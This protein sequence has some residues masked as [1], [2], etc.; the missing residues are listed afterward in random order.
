MA[1]ADQRQIHH[2]DAGDQQADG[3]DTGDRQGEGRENGGEGGQ[4]GVT[5]HHGHIEHPVARLHQLLQSLDQRGHCLP[6]QRLDQQTKQ[7]LGIEQP[8]GAAHRDQRRLGHVHPQI[9][10]LA[11]E[12]P[13][14]PKAAIVKTQPLADRL[15]LTE[16][17][18]GR[19]GPEQDDR[20]VLCGL[21]RQPAAGEQLKSVGIAQPVAA[22]KQH[23]LAQPRPLL[24]LGKAHHQR[25]Q[26]ELGLMLA[27]VV[28][29]VEGDLPQAVAGDR[30]QPAGG[31]LAAR[32]HH[33]QILAK[34]A[35]LIGH[36]APR[37]LPQR[38]EQQHRSDAQTHRQDQHQRP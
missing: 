33:Q 34:R 29:V 30:R 10:A 5:A 18:P 35:E 6:R 2:H 1:G 27:K 8:H 32:E 22:A 26:P 21:P 3:T 14:H 28:H 9:A 16:Q 15:G 20:P 24:G 38:G 7:P 4:H 13:H 23:G 25:H 17:L 12:D 11:G 19:H 37:P 31:L 36:I